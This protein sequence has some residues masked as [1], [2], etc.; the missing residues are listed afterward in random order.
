[1]DAIELLKAQHDEVEDLFAHIE[2]DDDDDD[3]EEL[4]QR[5][6]DNLAAHSTIEEKLFYPAAYAAKTSE[7]LR[8]A[9]EEHLEI[10]RVIA[11][12]LE[13]TPDDE[14]FDAKFK[15]LREQVEQHVDEE[16]SDLFPACAATLESA[17]LEALGADMKALFDDEMAKGPSESVLDQTTE[18]MPIR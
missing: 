13:M 5:L 8:E 2:R 7:M 12:L 6:A 14:N 1:M 18:A 11:E 3:K 4:F 10:K 9:V 15:V 16:E 17:E